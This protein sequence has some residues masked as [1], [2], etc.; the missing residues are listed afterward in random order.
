MLS[1]LLPIIYLAFIS[2]GL[3]DS[4]LGSAWPTIY[5]EFGVPVS[6]AGIVSAIIAVGTVISSLL[7]SRLISVLKTGG[8]TAISV[9]MTAAA[10]FGFSLSHSF[11]SLCLWAVPYGLGAG[12]VDAALN[13]YVALHYKSS[14]MSW[15]HCM[16]GIGATAGPYI[17]GRVLTDGL[18][19]TMGYRVL[20]F[21]QIA[22]TI[23]LVICIPVWKAADNEFWN[24]EERAEVEDDTDPE[25]NYKPL[26]LREVVRLP[27]VKA[28]MVAFFCYCGIE[29]TTG[30]WTA[31]YL[32]LHLGLSADFAATFTSLAFLGITIGRALNGFLAMKYSDMTLIRVG[33]GVIALGCLMLLLPIHFVP[34][35]LAAIL[36]VGLGCA[37]I[38]PSIIH[39][40]P[41]RFG[42]RKSQDIIGVQMASAYVGTTLMPPLF[43]LI[44]QYVSIR[45]WPVYLLV[46]L[47]LMFLMNE[48]VEKR[49]R[50]G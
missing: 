16:W 43:G 31:S 29:S 42:K 17:M 27:G 45:L 38:Y 34:F 30:L 2:L 41:F 32:N 46:L 47:V 8:V 39:A 7:S 48:R 15:L 26:P 19:W 21:I 20:S 37:P 28:I 36:L 25:E 12:S 44:A 13:N 9:A 5:P 1:F 49:I 22:L 11:W 33:Q 3:P 6:Y 14:H 10:L 24:E 40:T 50:E 35:Q 4:V 18:P 23:V